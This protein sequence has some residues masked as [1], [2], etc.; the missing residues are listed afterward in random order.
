MLFK[1]INELLEK[2]NERIYLKEGFI[3]CVYCNNIIHKDD[4]YCTNCGRSTRRAF[5]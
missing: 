4:N 5:F 1:K 3:H 2:H